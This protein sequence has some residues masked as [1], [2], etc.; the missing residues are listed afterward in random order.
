MAVVLQGVAK[1]QD[2]MNAQMAKMGTVTIDGL[3]EAS[4]II[5][6][7]TEDVS[8][9]TP[10]DTGN[11]RASWFTVTPRGKGGDNDGSFSGT[12]SAVMKS[13]HS[14]VISKETNVVKT[15]R[16]PTVAFGF[17]ANYAGFVHE[18]VG[19]NFKR[20]GSGAW[21]LAAA[22]MRTKKQVL[23]AIRLRIKT[24]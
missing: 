6:R 19:A 5:H 24:R 4:I 8:P 11:L 18:M 7:S 13:N 14:K 2:R 21:Y 12:D 22:I 10:L 15:R 16:N 1:M 3:I 17:S 23:E 20:P 9:I